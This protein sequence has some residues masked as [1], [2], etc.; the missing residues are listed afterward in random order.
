MEK[1]T[2]KKRSYNKKAGSN[3]PGRPILI[4][5]AEEAE[6]RIDEYFKQCE[7]K[8]KP[9]TVAGLTGA[10]GFLSRQTLLGYDKA[11]NHKN[12]PEEEQKKISDAIKKAK[13]KIEQYLEENLIDGR[14]VAG[15]IFNLKNNYNYI[16]RTDINH[17]GNIIFEIDGLEKF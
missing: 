9:F 13:L 5:T 16:D 3:P 14:Q 12:I 7:K 17:G 6:K 10:M 11:E 4:Q 1:Q 8:K 15:T 2:K